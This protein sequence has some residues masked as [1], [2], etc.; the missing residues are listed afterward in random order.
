MRAK[1]HNH[2]TMPHVKFIELIIPKIQFNVNLIAKFCQRITRYW[3]SIYNL[4]KQFQY[5]NIFAKNAN[6]N[7]ILTNNVI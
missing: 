1:Y 4:E 7:C 6:I 3:Q 2:S 5:F